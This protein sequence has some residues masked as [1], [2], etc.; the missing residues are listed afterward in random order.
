MSVNNIMSDLE[1]IF[2]D[3]KTGYGGLNDL[4]KRA[5]DLGYNHEE[6][7]I[8][9]NAQPVNQIYKT[10]KKVK[11][12]QNIIAPNLN[13]GSLQ[14]DLMIMEKYANKNGGYKYLLNVIDIYSRYGWSIPL[15][16]KESGEIAPHLQQ[17]ITKIKRKWKPEKIIF[18]FDQGSEF[19]GEVLKLFDKYKVEK[20]VNDPH[21]LNSHNTMGIIERFNKTISSKIKKIMTHNQSL[22][23]IKDVA[24]IVYNYNHTVHSGIM[25]KPYEIFTKKEQ[26]YIMIDINDYKDEP[27]DKFKVGDFVRFMKKEKAL[28]KK[29]FVPKYS[30]NVHKIIDKKGLHYILDNG[31]K[32]YEEQLLKT[33][34]GQNKKG[35]KQEVKQM[36]KDEKIKRDTKKEFGTNDIEQFIRN[37]KRSRKPVKRLIEEK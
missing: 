37:D 31:K 25:K 32:Y 35:F 30:L 12:H 10:K 22:S 21:S 33:K 34:E 20:H 16:N 28:E 26:P 4:W 13:V 3:S 2:Y 19:E 18:T 8:W 36:K 23:Y 15:K 17:I 14:A 9:Y 11:K 1:K 5:K 29:G 7:R 27:L 24:N 6:V